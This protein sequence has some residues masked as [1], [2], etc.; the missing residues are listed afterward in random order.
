[1]KTK[2]Y[3]ELS[4]LQTFKERFRYLKLNG[5]V[6]EDTFGGRRYL[7]Q[8]FYQTSTEWKQFRHKIIV[9]DDGC[10]LGIP[11]REIKG[12]IYIHH[13]EPL[14]PADFLNGTD[15]L[16]N[17]DNAIC[18]SFRTHQA[19]HYGDESILFDIPIERTKNDTCPWKK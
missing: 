7:N 6:G 16:L 17:P 9:R 1:M 13:I 5:V 12:P 19:I 15:A 11:G 8:K 10:D 3:T 4:T 2:T 18:T 14:T